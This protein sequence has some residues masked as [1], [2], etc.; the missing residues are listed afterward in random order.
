ML[1]TL[2]VIDAH[3]ML[4]E[5]A[6]LHLDAET[7][8]RR[9]DAAEVT[10]AIARPMGAGLVVDHAAGNALVLKAGP[11]IRGLVTA[12]PWWGGKALDAVARGRDDG[13]VGL[14][15]D[16]TRQG[17]MPTESIAMPLF[18]RAAEYGWPVLVRTGTYVCA[19]L[20]AVAE[21][22][23]R[24]PATPFIAGFGGFADMW[25]DLPGTFAAIPN[26]Y[27]DT[28]M[29]IGDGIRALVTAHGPSRIVFGSAEPRNRYAVCLRT[30]ERLGLAEDARRAILHDNAKRLFG[31]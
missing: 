28:S 17:F 2:P 29:M 1:N 26:L 30:L 4:G 21:V 13:A 5:E 24:L 23:R 15:L 25:F 22:A 14:F 3:A 20:L 18:E 12:N 7:L 27:V 10:M 19:D 8:L 31:L 9:M 11:R 16:P 6:H